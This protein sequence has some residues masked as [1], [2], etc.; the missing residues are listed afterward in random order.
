MLEVSIVKNTKKT[1]HILYKK[2]HD[3]FHRH[4]INK[5]FY[6]KKAVL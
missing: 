5:R 6:L 4:P 3:I 1:G 2:E